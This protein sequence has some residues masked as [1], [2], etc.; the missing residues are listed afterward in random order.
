M[1]ACKNSSRQ[2]SSLAKLMQDTTCNLSVHYCLILYSLSKKLLFIPA[3]GIWTGT[4]KNCLQLASNTHPEIQCLVSWS[5]IDL[6]W[7][8]DKHNFY[9]YDV[10]HWSNITP[11]YNIIMH[12]ILLYRNKYTRFFFGTFIFSV[13]RVNI[14][15]TVARYCCYPRDKSEAGLGMKWI[16]RHGNIALLYYIYVFMLARSVPSYSVASDYAGMHVIEAAWIRCSREASEAS[17]PTNMKYLPSLLL[18][19]FLDKECLPHFLHPSNCVHHDLDHLYVIDFSCSA[20]GYRRRMLQQKIR[21]TQAV[22]PHLR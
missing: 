15:I 17:L 20:N 7:R 22:S 14:L 19:R 1:T 13:Q 6:Q 12:M 18:D 5:Q 9:Y 11:I 4:H 8:M 2:S 21:Q 10:R 16:Y 3:A